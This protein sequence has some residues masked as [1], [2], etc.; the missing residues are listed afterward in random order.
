[1]A[2]LDGRGLEAKPSEPGR[3][4]HPLAASLDRSLHVCER[5]IPSLRRRRRVDPDP[6]PP[7]AVLPLVLARG[8]LPGDV[9]EPSRGGS[10]RV[11]L[12]RKGTVDGGFRRGWEEGWGKIDSAGGRRF[13]RCPL[14]SRNATGS[15][16]LLGASPFAN[17]ADASAT[18]VS[19]RCVSAA[20]SAAALEAATADALGELALGGVV[21]LW[22]ERAEAP[23]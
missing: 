1:M 19:R 7:G 14:A 20:I 5:G 15:S 16:P 11:F 22:A 4:I 17:F 10:T 13:E 21:H 6:P 18:A 12:L 23:I 8:R 3:S 9:R 2:V